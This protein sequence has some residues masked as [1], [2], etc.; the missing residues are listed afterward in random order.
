MGFQRKVSGTC[1]IHGGT[2]VIVPHAIRLQ[3]QQL[4]ALLAQE[5]VT[6]LSQTPSAFR[7]LVLAISEATT[8]YLSALSLIAFSGEPVEQH[9]IDRW[10]CHFGDQQPTLVNMYAAT[11]TSGEVAFQPLHSRETS[12]QEG[13][14]IGCA[15]LDS[16]LHVLD[17]TLK[18]I[19]L[20]EIGELYVGRGS[21]RPWLL[22]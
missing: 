22:A 11:E 10:F 12:A 1:S 8:T 7:G 14:P 18:Q 6:V 16:P 2:L 5:Q 3:P 9:V 15:L 13:S 20:G 4:L 17:R 19:P 21:H